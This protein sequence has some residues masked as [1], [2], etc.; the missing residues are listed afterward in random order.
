MASIEQTA[1][2]N[3]LLEKQNKLL[4]VQE[5]ML[6]NQLG[7]LTQITDMYDKMDMS[8]QTQQTQDFDRIV[9]DVAK[10]MDQVGKSSQSTLEAIAQ[11]M[12]ENNQE[13]TGFSNSLQK[14]LDKAPQISGWG[15]AFEGAAQGIMFTGSALTSLSSIATTA[16]SSMFNLA[17]SIL[18]FPFKI[19]QGLINATDGGGGS[20]LREALEA[21][22]TEFGDLKTG[23]SDAI[24]TISREMR[25]QL[26]ETGLSSYRIFGNLAERL[27]A[28]TEIAKA[29][30]P[31]FDL[32]R[33]SFVENGE[34]VGAYIKGLGLSE[35]GQK[36]LAQTAIRT[37]QDL[38]E[39]GREITTYAYQM[40][41]AF[42]FNGKQISRDVGEMMADI[43][44]F[45]TLSVQELTEVS[46][47]ARNLGLEFKD[48]QGVIDQFDNFENAAQ[49]AAQLSQ[50]FGLQL[51]TL[52][53]LNA[54]NPAERIEQLRKSFFAAGKS[55][56]TMTRQERAL[57][58]QQ[59][60][61]DEAALSL[62][63][64]LE[65]QNKSYAD[66]QKQ[67]DAT[68]KKQLSQAEA[69]EKL[70]NS[71]ERMVK[72]GGGQTGGFLDRFL[73]GFSTGIR[74]SRE[75]RKI[76]IN[77]RRS[78]RETF[79][80]GIRVGRDFVKN[81]D[82]VKEVFD[83][84]SEFFSP[85]RL[86]PKLKGVIDIFSGFFKGEIGLEDFQKRM[87]ENFADFFDPNSPIAKKFLSGIGKFFT[88]V[89]E[90]FGKG[91]NLGA[92][93]LRDG[94]D[95]LTDFIK[96]PSGVL[97]AAASGGE[98]IAGWFGQNVIGP[99]ISALDGPLFEDL[100]R[101]FG[102][103][104][105]ALADRAVGLFQ[106]IWE[107][108]KMTIIGTLVA[109][110]AGP[111]IVGFLVNGLMGVI[112]G[113]LLRGI[114][115][116]ILRV[117]GFFTKTF[118]KFNQ[119][120]G[121][122]A[123]AGAQGGATGG[124]VQQVARG[125]SFIARAID[126]FGEILKSAKRL[127]LGGAVKLAGA[128]AI[129]SG[130]GL[131][132]AAAFGTLVVGVRA[133][134]ISMEDSLKAAAFMTGAALVVAEMGAL[135]YAASLVGG[136]AAAIGPALLGVVT[137]MGLGALVALGMFG[138][139][140]ITNKISVDEA[141]QAGA[142]MGVGA[143]IVAGLG[144]TL[145]ALA[146]SGVVAAIG[147][148]AA[149]F[150]GAALLATVQGLELI[151]KFAALKL[152]PIPMNLIEQAGKNVAAGA[153]MIFGLGAIQVALAAVGGAAL[154]TGPLAIFGAAALFGIIEGVSRMLQYVI[155]N[156][157]GLPSNLIEEAA[158]KI[159]S[160]KTIISA[161]GSVATEVIRINLADVISN[162]MS[163]FGQDANDGIAG[164]LET[165]KSTI[166][167][168]I[169][170]AEGI[171]VTDEQRQKLESINTVLNVFKNFTEI[172]N[173][174]TQQAE[175]NFVSAIVNGETTGSRLAGMNRMFLGLV[176]SLNASIIVL[177]N[178]PT[179]S[180]DKIKT[181]NSVVTVIDSM[182]RFTKNLT[183]SLEAVPDDEESFAANVQRL[184]NFFGRV[185]DSILGVAGQVAGGISSIVTKE[186]LDP[187]TFGTVA[188]SLSKVFTSIGN[189]TK[190]VSAIALRAAGEGGEGVGDSLNNF[191]QGSFQGI[192]NALLQGNI[193]QKIGQLVGALAGAGEMLNEGSLEQ[194]EAF[195]GGF[196]TIMS[197]IQ[198]AADSVTQINESYVETLTDGVDGMIE[199]IN[200]IEDSLSNF[201][202]ANLNTKLKE[203]VHN[204]GLDTRR[205]LSI[206]HGDLQ[207]QI[208]LKVVMEADK[209][210]KVL[211][212][213]PNSRLQERS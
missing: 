111:A 109:V 51:D 126:S 181:I 197:S 48:L 57:L 29:M 8:E 192:I 184:Q 206:D 149:F 49:S 28:I 202:G 65:N 25:G 60:G 72:S 200:R 59:T 137:A 112:G 172:L 213:R 75:F 161:L 105:S 121:G 131:I 14:L 173:Q 148:A 174:T 39:V 93:F 79:Y 156:I 2:L 211:L 45:G 3:K 145:A 43:K 66:V 20:G 7:L 80:A 182:T 61:L 44:N 30:G 73:Q 158:A 175:P 163:Y 164:T 62:A 162:I 194:V 40:G 124:G 171:E 151:L 190:N 1:E 100:A 122:G 87:R 140:K 125:G 177:S 9:Q 69:M 117:V 77:L 212:D 33:D 88:K 90:L 196:S 4:S 187:E 132:F 102:D 165:M 188:T 146:V 123:A 99:F 198:Q 74:R 127:E 24:I 160:A 10:N 208:N 201:R 32:V 133:A 159:D 95:W 141:V 178:V 6:K 56:E 91:V 118:S 58:A 12:I 15:F 31:A 185:T 54:Q 21:I 70:S 35:D 157:G 34:R 115:P 82:G 18:T 170:A 203:M 134:N 81:F 199:S 47:Y 92:K 114:G 103:M 176:S 150:G 13:T 84:I 42:G 116:A 183:K 135:L 195:G 50:A 55:I 5:Q 120:V 67:S 130:V 106:R 46:V 142:V 71:I 110:F 27:K 41:E 37:G 22:R 19:L 86:R 166:Q 107:E 96:D 36:A 186:G 16:F 64:S 136:G 168:T 52:E 144:V 191:I 128:A 153:A 63:F 17:T 101:A 26:A 167:A 209:L 89:S 23:A 78:L 147:G 193:T 113:F 143:L 180:E 68:K 83:S 210:E 94:L 204:L 108:H 104:F 98:G 207:I 205:R 119:Q 85:N 38:Q 97:N 138:L 154:I 139:V 152:A 76:M 129:I 155:V 11:Q 53:L 189:L 169:E 179:L